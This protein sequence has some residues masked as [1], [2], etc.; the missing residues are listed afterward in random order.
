MLR[1]RLERVYRERK[2]GASPYFLNG[3]WRTVLA[4]H[5]IHRSRQSV[6]RWLSGV[7]GMPSD[8]WHVLAKIEREVRKDLREREESIG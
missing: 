4:A 8:A 2:P 3:W 6:T 5:G 7:C 1:E